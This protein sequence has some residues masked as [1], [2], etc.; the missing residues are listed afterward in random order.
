[1]PRRPLGR[2]QRVSTRTRSRSAV[3]D[4]VERPHPRTTIAVGIHT[5]LAA[6]RIGGPS[7]NTGSN[8]N[9]LL[10]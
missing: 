1:M 8:F 3:L 7:G 9:A 2:E 4:H 6:S 5:R 10:R